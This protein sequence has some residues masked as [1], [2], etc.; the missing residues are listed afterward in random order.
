ME[1]RLIYKNGASANL[2]QL[3]LGAH[4]KKA[5]RTGPFIIVHRVS[6]LTEATH[7][8]AAATSFQFFGTITASIT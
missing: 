8:A 7:H 3:R 1:C 4:S 5:L 6:S 2:N